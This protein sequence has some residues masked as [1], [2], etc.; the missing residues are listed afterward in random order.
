MIISFLP[1]VPSID[2]TKTSDLILSYG[3]YNVCECGVIAQRRPFM[4][5]DGFVPHPPHKFRRTSPFSYWLLWHLSVLT[6]YHLLSTNYVRVRRFFCLFFLCLYAGFNY[7]FLDPILTTFPTLSLV[8]V[9]YICRVSM[10]IH[11]MPTSQYFVN[12]D[13]CT[14]FVR[15]SAIIFSVLQYAIYMLLLWTRFLAKI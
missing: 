15:K 2:L 7:F 13:P 10:Y 11:N 1:I 4:R 9:G 6:S 12:R 8:E 5:Q 14:T 3:H